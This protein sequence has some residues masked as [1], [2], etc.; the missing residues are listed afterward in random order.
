M[1]IEREMNRPDPERQAFEARHL[2]AGRLHG[3]ISTVAVESPQ[4]PFG[5]VAPYCLDRDGSTVF[6]LSHLAQ[7][8]KNLLGNPRASLTVLQSFEGD[9]QQASRLSGVGE[10]LPMDADDDTVI[11]YFRYF[12][13]SRMYFEELGFLFFR[14]HPERWHFNSG[15]A[16]ARWFG[17]D[18]IVRR[19]PFPSDV[20]S[21][22][23]EHMN[24]DHQPALR[25][26]LANAGHPAS[27]SAE[28]RLCGVDGEGMDIG[29]D[30]RI[31]RIP[32]PRPVDTLDSLRALLIEMA[33]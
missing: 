15:F 3:V 6:L 9:V 12:P 33:R 2:L 21:S 4:Q 20:E 8:T 5:S 24:S 18:R 22:A 11:R 19:N 1:T 32:Y 28:I 10:I 27:V 31:W 26:Y 25:V 7:H 30:D 17:N 13:H 23:I 29:V 14:L 16:T